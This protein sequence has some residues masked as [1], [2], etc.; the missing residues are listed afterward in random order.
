MTGVFWRHVDK[1]FLTE[2]VDVE[3]VMFHDVELRTNHYKSFSRQ[4]E[5]AE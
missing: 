5:I 1:T 2:S 4:L 3:L